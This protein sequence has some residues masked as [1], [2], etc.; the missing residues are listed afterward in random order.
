MRETISS[1][2]ASSQK[3]L[4]TDQAR[5]QKSLNNLKQ[6]QQ[7]T[8][9]S[10]PQLSLNVSDNEVG[11]DAVVSSGFHTPQGLQGLSRDSRTLDLAFAL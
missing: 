3:I 2:D 7:V 11:L 8:D 1:T 5:L 9:T 4:Q 10:Q 6:A